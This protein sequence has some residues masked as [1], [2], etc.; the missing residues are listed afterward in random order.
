MHHARK[1][2]VCLDQYNG[3]VMHI[4]YIDDDVEDCEIFKECVEAVDHTISCV[5][6]TNPLSA[7]KDLRHNTSL[8]D[9]IF[10]DTNMPLMSGK[11]LFR[12]IKMIPRL[13][14]IP[15][16]VIS[17]AF[18][19]LEKEQYSTL[20]AVNFLVKPTS[21]EKLSDEIRAILFKE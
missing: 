16:I 14:S 15:V 20:G 6:E 10:L 8:P 3:V 1:F 5:T 9:F 4:L 18:G 12:E 2:F 11:E 21:F 17:T 19:A 13:S 7:L